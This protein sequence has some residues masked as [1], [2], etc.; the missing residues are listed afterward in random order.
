MEKKIVLQKIGEVDQVVLTK[1]KKNLEWI[2]KEFGVGVE[3]SLESINLN[4][5][6]YVETKQQY[7]ASL[8]LDRL[9]QIACSKNILRVLG[10]LDKDIYSSYL[11]FV[12]GIAMN[13]I[14]HY[15]NTPLV[16]LI[17]LVRLNEKFYTRP[18]NDSLFELRTM[19]EAIHELGHT[20]SLN[21]CN[22]FCIMRFSNHLGD[23]DEK[24]AKF[25]DSCE[26]KLIIFFDNLLTNT[27]F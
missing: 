2:F 7:D 26:K 8:I 5:S 13:P 12:F 27:Q 21:H 4:A 16:C 20:F 3:I 15:S 22:N 17:S 18:E 25:C 11:N 19:K 10:I 9:F 23:T 6:E 24:P 14:K 1:L